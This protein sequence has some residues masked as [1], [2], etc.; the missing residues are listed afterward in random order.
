MF[1]K[2]GIKDFLKR[3][4]YKKNFYEFISK[5]DLPVEYGKEDF[6]EFIKNYKDSFLND[7]NSVLLCEDIKQDVDDLYKELLKQR[8]FISTE[9]DDIISIIEFIESSKYSLAEEM[10][11]KLFK[12]NFDDYLITTI[13]NCNFS[14]PDLFRIRVAKYGTIKDKMELFHVPYANR[15]IVQN[16]RYN[17]AGKPCLYLSTSLNLAWIECGYPSY[18][19]FAELKYKYESG[20]NWR[21]KDWKFLSFL[22]PIDVVRNQLGCKIENKLDKTSKFL[23]K[24]LRTFPLIFACSIIN[25]SKTDIYKPEY[26]MPQLIMQWIERNNKQL[27]GILY[28]P[29]TRSKSIHVYNGYNIALPTY[30][31]NKNGYSNDLLEKFSI[32]K[33]NFSQNKMMDEDI[34]TIATLYKDVCNYSTDLTAINECCDKM[35]KILVHLKT[36]SEKVESIPSDI[37]VCF[38]ESILANIDSFKEKNY[39]NKIDDICDDDNLHNDEKEKFKRIYNQFIGL[40]DRIDEFYFYIERGVA[41][42]NY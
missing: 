23:I 35:L 16:N 25:K 17:I 4:W 13:N 36:L 22:K 31:Y 15:G 14:N 39:I 10:V 24:Y 33:I 18:F 34:Q 26:I 41:K 42:D 5:Y 6:L 20:I 7:Y 2:T 11:D 8:D 1:E 32:E 3:K 37:L 21:Q 38:V 29:C 9:F 19:Y 30:N 28:F 12:N 27:K 40:T